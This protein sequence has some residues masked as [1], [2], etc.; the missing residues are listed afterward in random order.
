MAMELWILSDCQL[1]TFAECS[2]ATS[3]CCK[4]EAIYYTNNHYY[5]FYPLDLVADGE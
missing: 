5:S 2:G 3:D 4:S 1:G